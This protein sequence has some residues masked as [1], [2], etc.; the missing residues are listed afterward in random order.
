MQAVESAED[1][2]L[3]EAVFAALIGLNARTVLL[4]LSCPGLEAYLRRQ[5]GLPAGSAQNSAGI[6]ALDS[7]AV[8]SP[9]LERDAA[10]R[11]P[12]FLCEWCACD[13]A[14]SMHVQVK[15]AQLV[16]QLHV[17]RSEYGAAAGVLYALATRKSGA[18]DKAVT[19]SD[20]L[21]QLRAAS[22]QVCS[23]YIGST[24]HPLSCRSQPA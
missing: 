3:H 10:G 12:T 19:L 6:D 20:R 4:D 24:A 13:I 21:E 18:G 22:L 9:D 5:A 15:H 17:K 1:T 14:D 2:R 7:D 8:R 23:L 16:V 11:M